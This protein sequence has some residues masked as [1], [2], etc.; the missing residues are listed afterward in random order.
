MNLISV[1]V[2]VYNIRQYLEKCIESIIDQTYRNLEI[3]LVDDGSTDNS[4]E[5]CDFYSNK[6]S[7][8]NVLHQENKGLS[9]ARNA[10]MKVARGDWLAFVDGDDWIESNMFEKMLDIGKEYDADL[11][12]SRFKFATAK[13]EFEK[14]NDH[15]AISIFEGSELIEE[16]IQK[17]KNCMI[18][19]SVWD[20]LYKKEILDGLLFPEGRVHEDICFTV[21]VFCRCKRAVYIDH[22]F[23]NYRV[24]RGESISNSGYDIKRIEDTIVLTEMAERHLIEYK[25]ESLAKQLYLELYL[26][27]TNIYLQLQDISTRQY[28]KNYRMKN[29]NKMVSIFGDKNIPVKKRVLSLVAVISPKMMK[30]MTDAY[31]RVNGAREIKNEVL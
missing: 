14:E 31:I 15:D 1:I 29:R 11:V 24:D 26:L 18:S 16:Y 3:I 30:F 21:D 9:A 23:Y 13:I 27:L 25:Q 7:R 20:R 10:G 28:I 17:K 4:G 8:I 5:I 6:D 19:P 2:P 22:P 12:L